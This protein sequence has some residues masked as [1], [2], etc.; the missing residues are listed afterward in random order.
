M[1]RGHASNGDK[2]VVCSITV[3][4]RIIQKGRK[5]YCSCPPTSPRPVCG[6][7]APAV[8]TEVEAAGWVS[9]WRV[10]SGLASGNTL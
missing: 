2:M 10:S 4:E 8:S 1:V 7:P 3:R 6:A 5:K 9:T